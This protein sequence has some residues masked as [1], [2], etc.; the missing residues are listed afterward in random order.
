MARWFQ[1]R[2]V[3]CG[4]EPLRALEA[5]VASKL[6]AVGEL[7]AA[8][9]ELFPARFEDV[10]RGV[11]SARPHR[12]RIVAETAPGGV[13]AAVR[14]A[15][16]GYLRPND[17]PEVAVRLAGAPAEVRLDVASELLHGAAPDRNALLARWVWNPQRHT[18]VLSDL[19]GPAENSYAHVQA[20]LGEIRLELSALGF[21][22][23]T[24]AGVDVVLALTYAARLEQATDGPLRSGGLES[25]LPGAFP[26]ASMI[27]GVRRRRVDAHR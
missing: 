2:A 11:V 19:G 10:L 13:Q 27:L 26:L 21:P 12:A 23:A 15:R 3:P 17:L 16:E 20:R 22:C 1:E 8:S 25:L 7:E 9:V 4:L 6:A 14:A 5:S 24:F 18:G